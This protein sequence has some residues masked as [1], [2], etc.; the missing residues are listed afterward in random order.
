VI[1]RRSSLGLPWLRPETIRRVTSLMAGEAAA[2]PRRLAELMTWWRRMRYVRVGAAS[3]ARI[4]EQRS[5]L[6]VHRCW[7]S[8]SGPR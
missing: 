8:A 3:I 2:E 1:A 7:R 6:L 5:T 4:A